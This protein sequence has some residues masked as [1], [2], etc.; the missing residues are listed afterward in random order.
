MIPNFQT[1]DEKIKIFYGD[2]LSVLFEIEDES[3]NTC[4][5]SPPYY[6]LRD[7]GI[8]GQYG[9]ESTPDEYIEVLVNVFREVRRVLRNDGT[10]WI[11]LGDSYCANRTYQVSPTKHKNLLF[12]KSNAS[13]VPD[14]LKPK[15]IMG[16]PW[17][18]AF[19]L[20]KDGWFLR[21]DIIWNKTNPMPESVKDRCTKSHE[22]I[23]LLSK[24]Q[25]YYYDNES[26]KEPVA[27]STI[28]RLSQVNLKNQ[29]GS[30][31]VPGKTN[32]NM[33]A[34]GDCEKRNKR[35]VWSVSTKPYKEA[36]FATFPEDLIIPCILA[37]CP[38]DGLVLDPFSGSGTTGIVSLKLNRRFLGIEI[39]KEYI[40]ISEKRINDTLFDNKFKSNKLF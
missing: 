37:G 12:G 6:G 2:S 24:S 39:N 27:E 30:E 21:Q 33:K 23:F 34:V 32:G 29:N 26:I 38:E 28:Q 9:L 25:K 20:Q 10:L 1:E 35:S 19:A 14:G 31:R 17:R 36:H 18:V 3:I 5:T 15:D 11:N 16:I 8:E 13:K 40:D 7:Y 22:Y 4:V